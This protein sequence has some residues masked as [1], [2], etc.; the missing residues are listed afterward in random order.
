MSEKMPWMRYATRAL[1]SFP[2]LLLTSFYATWVAGRQALGY[3][4]RSSFDDPKHI[5][6]GL[7]GLYDI[8]QVLI[9]VGIP[10]FCSALSVLALVCFYHRPE[11]WKSRLRELALALILFFGLLLFGRWDPHSVIEWYFD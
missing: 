2:T 4:P 1:C 5:K 7:M 8:T 6:G 10:L 11:G 9:I 3:W